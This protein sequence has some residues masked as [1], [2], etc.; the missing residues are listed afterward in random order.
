MTALILVSANA[1]AADA[2]TGTWGPEQADGSPKCEGLPVL[3]F[4]D[5][6][7]FRVLP[8]VGSTGGINQLILSE[9]TYRLS[10]DRLVVAQALSFTNP[11]PRQNFL[12]QRI[13]GKALI[14]QGK[15]RVTFRPC[16]PM[17]P[18]TLDSIVK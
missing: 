14:L 16:P 10:G 15:E 8:N 5:G 11:Q 6:R 13:G 7:Y 17:D 1:L 4:H 12:V 3:L 18:K 2:V 9:S